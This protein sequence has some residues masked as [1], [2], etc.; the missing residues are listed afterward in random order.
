M[1]IF[2]FCFCI[3]IDF[4]ATSD[5][6]DWKK[7]TVIPKIS[8]QKAH[9]LSSIITT[10]QETKYTQSRKSYVPSTTRANEQS[11]STAIQTTMSNHQTTILSSTTI[12]NQEYIETSLEN[13]MTTA[14][15][16]TSTILIQKSKILFS[17]VCC[18][19]SFFFLFSPRS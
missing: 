10:E 19:Y 17:M 18:Y 4:T 15:S 2:V 7:I 3:T 14:N 16:F 9:T 6:Q 1:F 8:N 11:T 12:K 5:K 13:S